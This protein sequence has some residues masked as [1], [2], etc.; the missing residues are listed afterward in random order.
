VTA[1]LITEV[2]TPE[3]NQWF[4]EASRDDQTTEEDFN[5]NLLALR[6]FA[7]SSVKRLLEEYDVNVILGPSDSRTASTGSASGLPWEIFHWALQTSMVGSFRST[8]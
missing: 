8:W 4:L 7:S 5:R 2:V 3:G 1:I 6:A